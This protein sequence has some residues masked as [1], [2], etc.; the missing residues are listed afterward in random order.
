MEKLSTRHK[1]ILKELVNLVRDGTLDD[2]FHIFWGVDGAFIPPKNKAGFL[3]A[4]GI[5]RIALQALE[6]EELI[7]SEIH[8][9]TM[10]SEFGSSTRHE[11]RE[12]HRV[13]TIT[14]RGYQ[15][16]DN[17]FMK[18]TPI[19]GM[20]P[21]VEIA[22]SLD[23]F[24]E[25]FPDPSK[26]A[27]IMMQF[28]STTAHEKIVTAIRNTLAPFGITALRADDREY[29][30]DL[31][32]N[33]LTYIYGCRF[34]VAV[35]ERIEADEFNPNV[36]LEVGYMLGLKKSVCLLKDRTLKTLHTDLVGKLYRQFNPLDPEGTIPNELSKW[37]SDRGLAP[38]SPTSET[39][40]GDS[41]EI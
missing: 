13:C 21:P 12:R 34:G 23:R 32:P 1:D 8:T 22:D 26:T 19:V 38:V 11:T 9:E 30:E 36:S 35:F 10:V 24:R 39:K 41:S 16:V 2:E 18:T 28:G 14:P 31:F 33:I 40:S 27:F 37:I 15:V 6:E 4:P 3:S 20:A 5:T 25:D 17:D 29:H 7:R